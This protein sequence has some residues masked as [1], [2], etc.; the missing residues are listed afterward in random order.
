MSRGKRARA[1]GGVHI[2][3][4]P[5]NDNP[6]TCKLCNQEEQKAPLVKE[7]LT[8]VGQ[9]RMRTSPRTSRRVRRTTWL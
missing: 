9:T 8:D 4:C 5:H 3:L 1:T 7:T 2:A 6:E